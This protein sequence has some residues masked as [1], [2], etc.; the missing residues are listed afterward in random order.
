[1]EVEKVYLQQEREQKKMRGFFPVR[2]AQGQNDN[3]CG[4]SHR[5]T[6]CD[7][8]LNDSNFSSFFTQ[9]RTSLFENCPQPA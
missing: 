6:A 7:G 5:K 8:G 9:S 3:F 4:A 2:C 1:M